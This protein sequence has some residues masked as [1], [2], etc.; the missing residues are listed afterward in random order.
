MN[1]RDLD[2]VTGDA[3]PP[4]R[5]GGIVE[6][7]GRIKEYQNRPHHAAEST[8]KQKPQLPPGVVEYDGWKLP[9]ELNSLER[10]YE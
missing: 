9:D 6:A 8:T 5:K 4:Q 3:A 7:V 2:V 1:N 10:G